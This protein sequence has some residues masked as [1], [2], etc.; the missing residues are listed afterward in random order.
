M[1]YA[2]S[3]ILALGIT[4]ALSAQVPLWDLRKD[5]IPEDLNHGAIRAGH[6]LRRRRSPTQWTPE[7]TTKQYYYIV[8]QY[9][10]L[11]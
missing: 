10:S 11:H 8:L 1:K 7:S 5:K 4:T 3:T 9:V 6:R 2:L